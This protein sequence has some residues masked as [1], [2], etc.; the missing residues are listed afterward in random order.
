MS[1]LERL[2]RDRWLG[3]L[4]AFG[5]F[6]LSRPYPGIYHDGR[7]YVADALA[8]LDPAGVGRDLMFVHDGQ[9]GFSLYTPILARLIA[10]LGPSG[11]TMAIVALTLALWF[12]AAALMVER[13]LADRPPAVR[14]TALIFVLAL[15]SLYGPLNVI[16]FGEPYATPRGLVEAAGLAGMAAY[17]SGRRAMGLAICGVGMLFHPIMGLCSAAA[18]AL[19][20]CLE[21]R[22]WLWAG[23]AGLAVLAAAGAAHLPIADRMVTVMDPAWRAVVEARSPIL[24]P[25][26][27]PVEAWGRLAVQACTV[28]AA[29]FLLRGAPR[30]LALGALIAGL[31]GVAAVAVLGDRLSLLLFLQV[32]SWRMLQPMAVLALA[33]LALLVAELP[34]RGPSGLFGLA[35]LGV[36]WLV[37]DVAAL[38]LLLAPVGLLFVAA[39]DRLRFSR[40][41]LFSGLALGLLLV[42]IAGC[43]MLWSMGLARR[44]G[45]LGTYSQASV[46]FSDLPAIAIAVT[47]G[48]WLALKRPTPPRAIRLAGAVAVGLLAILLWDDRTAYVRARDQGRDPALVAMTAARPGPVLWLVGDVEPW[49]LLGRASWAARVQG[50]GVVFSRP[51]SIAIRDRSDRLASLGLVGEDFVRPQTAPERRLPPPGPAQVRRLCAAPDAPAW[52][53]WPRWD[54]APPLAPSLAARDWT[55]AAPFVHEQVEGGQA[56][57]LKA[58]R[59]AVIPCAGG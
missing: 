2:T 8:K 44:L 12:A 47:L 54:D 53:I 43:S 35:L 22:R 4:A 33:S 56:R 14:W 30:R 36:A 32:Q 19:A 34:G 15:P 9:F 25:S 16:G 57:R 39:G 28:A 58:S 11:A 6:L 26:L 48:V 59:Y 31:A 40:P 24:F 42:A 29:A 38:G 37:R 49:V 55:P 41:K 23:L 1:R 46:W 17:L 45:L 10:L 13:L 21:D 52:I 51:L 3:V 7:L 50:A 18:I 20:L 27:W 5:V